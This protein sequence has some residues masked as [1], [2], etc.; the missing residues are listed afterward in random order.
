MYLYLL[1]V[2]I[3][4]LFQWNLQINTNYISAMVHMHRSDLSRRIRR[5]NSHKLCTLLCC[6][7]NLWHLLVTFANKLDFFGQ[8]WARNCD[9]QAQQEVEK[10]PSWEQMGARLISVQSIRSLPEWGAPGDLRFGQRKQIRGLEVKILDLVHISVDKSWERHRSMELE[11]LIDWLSG[12]IIQGPTNHLIREL[13][14]P[15][16]DPE[17]P[18]LTIW[19]LSVS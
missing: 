2:N 19:W 6:V 5:G 18:P 8:F 16:L 13:D 17:I 4:R 14:I 7:Q 15:P 3:F 9:Q 1:F 11:L 12:I 10:L